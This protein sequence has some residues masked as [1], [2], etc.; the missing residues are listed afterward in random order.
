M[1]RV[2]RVPAA[3]LRGDG[4]TPVVSGDVVEIN[5][6]GRRVRVVSSTVD[7]GGFISVEETYRIE[8]A[9]IGLQARPELVHLELTREEAEAV[10]GFYKQALG[11]RPDGNGTVVPP[12]ATPVLRELSN[13]V[14]RPA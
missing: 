8:P 12:L 7:A 2:T 1:P 13:V 10:V 11:A 4:S 14:D 6:G 5:G 3:L 9:A